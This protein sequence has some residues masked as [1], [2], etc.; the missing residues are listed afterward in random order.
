MKLDIEFGWHG[1][2]WDGTGWHGM[3]WNG[4]GWHGMAFVR[5]I[6]LVC[7]VRLIGNW[8]WILELEM[9]IGN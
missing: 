7:L 9:E 4:M 2:A 3:A 6:H 8:N 1:M 5:L